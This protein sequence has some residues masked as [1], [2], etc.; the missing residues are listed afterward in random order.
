M[1]LFADVE[2]WK[3]EWKQYGNLDACVEQVKGTDVSNAEVYCKWLQ[4]TATGSAP[5]VVSNE[6]FV[7]RMI[8]AG[9]TE[10]DILKIVCGKKEIKATGDAVSP[11][12]PEIDIE[13]GIH[14]DDVLYQIT[15]Q[16]QRGFTSGVIQGRDSRS[17]R[18]GDWRGSWS[19]KAN[20]W[21]NVEDMNASI[22]DIGKTVKEEKKEIKAKY[23]NYFLRD[24]TPELRKLK[25]DE[26]RAD[27]PDLIPALENGDDIVIGDNYDPK[28]YEI[29]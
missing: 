17:P 13:N 23:G 3:A 21:L 28:D 16:I 20:A 18:G 5:A 27:R 4:D 10:Q 6:Q 15:L 8:V 29:A 1:K 19:L 26:I 2:K 11:S 22:K 25:E 12:Q 14:Q 9:L 7:E 24:L